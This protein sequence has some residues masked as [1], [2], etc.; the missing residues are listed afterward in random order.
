MKKLKIKNK[1]KNI[2]QKMSL[3][4]INK[5]LYNKKLFNKID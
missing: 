3:N 4:L 1:F 5:K 2:N